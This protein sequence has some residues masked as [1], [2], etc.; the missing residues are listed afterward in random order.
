MRT[1]TSNL[2][3]T[4]NQYQ[5]TTHLFFFLGTDSKILNN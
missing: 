4:V 3:L 2:Q 5:Q 1:A